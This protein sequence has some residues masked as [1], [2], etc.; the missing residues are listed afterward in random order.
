MGFVYRQNII[1]NAVFV[2]IGFGIGLHIKDH[3]LEPKWKELFTITK[4]DTNF[5]VGILITGDVR[6]T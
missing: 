3:L 2:A 1:I 6:G 5:H 4:I